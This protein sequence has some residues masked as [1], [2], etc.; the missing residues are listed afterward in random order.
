VGLGVD[1][2]GWHPVMGVVKSAPGLPTMTLTN[3]TGVTHI[4]AQ[5]WDGLCQRCHKRPG[6][7]EVH[8]CP[9]GLTH[10]CRQCI[11]ES[12]LSHAREQAARIPELEKELEQLTK[13]PS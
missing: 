9:G 8:G 1:S 5:P 12:M 6:T 4:A 11:V 13:G 7:E 2:T 3:S 10:E